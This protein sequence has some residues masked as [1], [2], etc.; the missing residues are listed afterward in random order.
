M[1]EITRAF[2]SLSYLIEVFLVLIAVSG[3]SIAFKGYKAAGTMIGLGAGLHA[4]GYYL[5]MHRDLQADTTPLKELVISTMYP[6]FLLLTVGICYLAY[7]LHSKR[8]GA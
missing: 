4:L 6:G 8:R 3:L 7:S 2:Q 5:L 1:E